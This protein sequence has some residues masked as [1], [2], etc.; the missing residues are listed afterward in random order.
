MGY[1]KIRIKN[2][3]AGSKKHTIIVLLFFKS[4]TSL[5]S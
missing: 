2:M 5:E 1:K 4:T 3:S